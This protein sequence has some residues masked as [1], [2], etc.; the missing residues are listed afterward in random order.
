MATLWGLE[1]WEFIH[2]INWYDIPMQI[3]KHREPYGNLF[4]RQN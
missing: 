2:G 4:A 3:I 1:G